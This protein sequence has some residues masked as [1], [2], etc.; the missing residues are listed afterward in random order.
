MPT[1]AE[2]S[3]RI[4]TQIR[5]Y[6]LVEDLQRQFAAYLGT[7]TRARGYPPYEGEHALIVEVSPALAIERVID[8][9]LREVPGI[10][11][12]ILYVERQFGVLEIHSANLEDV[13]R[14]GEAILAGTGNKASDQL[15]PQVLYH[16]I[17]ENI[18]DQHAVILNRNRQA[19]MILPGQSLLVYEMTPALFAAVAANEAER[20]APG[21]TV[22]DVQMIGA[23]GRLYIGGSTADVTVARDRITVVLDGIE[24]RSHQ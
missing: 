14:A 12:G 17:I 21:L 3:T 9:A 19:S 4:R 13:R 20:A 6:L 2:E 24:G 16:D 7:P 8:L 18:T 22:V 11:P 23:A 1:K 10:Q 15:R 5:V